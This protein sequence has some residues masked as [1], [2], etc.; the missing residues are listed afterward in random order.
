VSEANSRDHWSKQ[1]TRKKRQ[2]NALRA[3]WID[4]RFPVGAKPMRVTFTRIGAR[5]LDDDNLASAFKAMRDE[6]AS[7]CGCDDGKGGPEWRYAQEARRE[8]PAVLLQVEWGLV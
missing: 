4:A 5:T 6:V 2:R 3:A 8:Q 7:L 1:A